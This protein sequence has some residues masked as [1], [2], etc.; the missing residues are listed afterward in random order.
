VPL[1]AD[2]AET[3]ADSFAKR[4]ILDIDESDADELRRLDESIHRLMNT[5]ATPMPRVAPPAPVLGL[6]P[7][8]AHEDDSP[9]LDPD[10]L[11]PPRAPRRANPFASEAAKILLVSAITA[12]ATYFVASWLQFPDAPSDPAAIFAIARPSGPPAVTAASMELAASTPAPLASMLQTSAPNAGALK[13]AAFQ[14]APVSNA[15]RDSGEAAKTPP[16][17]PAAEPHVIGSQAGEVI[18][19]AMAEPLKAAPESPVAATPPP[20]AASARPTPVL[21]PVKP[22]LGPDEIAMMVERSRA[23]FDAGDVASA[24]VF[25]RRAANAGDSQAAVAMGSTYDPEV[26]AERFIRGMQGNAEEARRWY[27]MAK[28]MAQHVE[29]LAQRR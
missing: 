12:P 22:T 25:F 16:S 9:L 2:Y 10:T 15:V 3:I 4:D 19:V 27:D 6:A 18:V 7:L 5:D 28:G 29:M 14:Q 23:F 26:L 20:E 13:A 21:V 11:F 17:K 8:G 1:N 24:R